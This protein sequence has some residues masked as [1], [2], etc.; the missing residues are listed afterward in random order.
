MKSSP[1]P[2]KVYRE[3]VPPK[4]EA[5]VTRKG[6]SDAGQIQTIWRVWIVRDSLQGN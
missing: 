6:E 2:K 4:E 1:Q 3:G 5:S